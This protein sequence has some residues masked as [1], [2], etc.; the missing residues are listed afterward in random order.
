LTL[1]QAL[2]N[3]NITIAERNSGLCKTE[4]L[5]DDYTLS[6]NIARFG[7]KVQ[8][9]IELCAQ[10][11]WRAPGGQPFSPFLFHKY[12]IPNEQKIKEMLMILGTPNGQPT[13]VGAGW[14]LLT[15]EAVV[16]YQKEWGIKF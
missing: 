13:P 10:L 2:P 5:I 3:I 14:G 11:G 1:E 4:H 6:R 9:V 12:T 15:P 16:A 7:L 8:T